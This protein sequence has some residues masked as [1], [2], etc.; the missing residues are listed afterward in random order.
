MG[1]L[2]QAAADLETILG[3]VDGFSSCIELRAPDNTAVEIRALVADVSQTIDPQTGM[4][5]SGRVA[6]VALPLAELA[7][8]P[9]LASG[10]V[11]TDKK[12]WVV[13]MPDVTGAVTVFRVREAR[14]DRVL[15]VLVCLLE[16][17]KERGA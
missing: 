5:V 8:W 2:D 13:R 14:P 7:D 6:S 15:G 11:D 3:D 16:P 9:G 1:L 4:A 17:Y 10:V 12:P